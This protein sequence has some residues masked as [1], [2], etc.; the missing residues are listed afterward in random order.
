MK[1]HDKGKEKRK[2]GRKWRM[3]K[4]QEHEIKGRGV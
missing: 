2:K 4:A 3:G 1:E